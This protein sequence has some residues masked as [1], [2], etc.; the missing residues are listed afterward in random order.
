VGRPIRLGIMGRVAYGLVLLLF[1]FVLG[2]VFTDAAHVATRPHLAHVVRVAIQTDEEFLASREARRGNIVESLVHRWNAADSWDRTGFKAL[3]RTF[4]NFEDVRFLP[5]L[6]WAIDHQTKTAYPNANAAGAANYAAILRH[7]VAVTLDAL[8][9]HELAETQRKR[10]AELVP[11]SSSHA[12]FA[13]LLQSE[14]NPTR[15]EVENLTL[16]RD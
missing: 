1:G 13:E 12:S 16:N 2:A 8:S 9:L 5:L 15:I 10:A 7:E 14:D 4:T 6:L 11:A 3:D